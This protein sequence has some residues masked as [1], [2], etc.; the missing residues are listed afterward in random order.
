M[1]SKWKV[2]RVGG[3]LTELLKSLSGSG[4]LPPPLVGVLILLP[5]LDFALPPACRE[6]CLAAALSAL[7]AFSAFTALSPPFVWTGP[8][9]AC[10]ACSV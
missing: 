7:S 4:S 5:P 6:V 1:S 3:G 2:T 8:P 9:S 10:S